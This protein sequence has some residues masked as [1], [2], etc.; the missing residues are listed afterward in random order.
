MSPQITEALLQT[1]QRYPHRRPGSRRTLCPAM[2]G[3]KAFMVCGVT[4]SSATSHSC[5]DDGMG[6]GRV[7]MRVRMR[8]HRR[9]RVY[10][11]PASEPQCRLRRSPADLPTLVCPCMQFRKQFQ[12]AMVT[13]GSSP[14]LPPGWPPYPSELAAPPPA[15][16]CAPHADRSGTLL[17]LR[18]DRS[19]LPALAHRVKPVTHFQAKCALLEEVAQHCCWGKTP[20]KEHQINTITASSA[21]HYTLRSFTEHRAVAWVHEPFT[22]SEAVSG[23]DDGEAPG[24]W[25]VPV[26]PGALFVDEFAIREV[27]HTAVVKVRMPGVGSRVRA[28]ACGCSTRQRRKQGTEVICCGCVAPPHL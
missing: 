18:P 12:S 16:L 9:A 28:R 11:L 6:V 4:V 17:L 22:G 10:G 5:V 2:N 3:L 27:A 13:H 23:P 20:A 8:Q 7:G 21:F 19:E 14:L 25:D 15:W 1:P 24:P 26:T